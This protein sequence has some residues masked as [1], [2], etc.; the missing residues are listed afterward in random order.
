MCK[1][2]LELSLFEGLAKK[3]CM[4][5]LALS[6]L[7]LS[8]SVLKVK[9]DSKILDNERVEKE[10]LMH[11]FKDMCMALQNLSRPNMKL[12]AIKKK[13]NDEKYMG[14]SRFRIEQR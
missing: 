10:T 6:A 4:K 11:C 7:M 2:L 12:R 5:T 13:Y 14:V 9:S 8:D 3:Y 1:Y